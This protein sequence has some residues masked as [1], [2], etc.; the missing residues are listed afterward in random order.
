MKPT[1]CNTVN[2]KSP[3]LT[4][5][6]HNWNGKTYHYCTTHIPPTDKWP[7]VIPAIFASC[8]AELDREGIVGFYSSL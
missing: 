5:V 8:K 2:C 6:R 7:V 3:D 1:R 4:P